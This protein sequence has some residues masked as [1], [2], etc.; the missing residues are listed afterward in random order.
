MELQLRRRTVL[1]AGALALG[2]PHAYSANA[3]IAVSTAIN[4]AGRLRALSQRSA[5]AYTQ[6]LLGILPE[7]AREIAQVAQ[8]LIGAHL[9]ELTHAK[10]PTEVARLLQRAVEM[11]GELRVLME[12][13]RT[14]EGALAV[15]R[16]ADLLLEAA[17][18]ATTAYE[19]LGKASSARLINVAARQRML[20]QRMTK[21]YFL[22]AAGYPAKTYR[23]PIDSDRA[24]F[25]QALALLNGSA[26]STP[27]IRNELGLAQTQWLFFEAALSKPGDPEALRNVATT[28]ERLLETMN[29]LTELYDGALKDLL[30]KA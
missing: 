15:S 25:T 4:R 11:A 27:S 3:Q 21:N 8:R 24:A 7:H 10:P 23:D 9:E 1:R 20:S 6:E 30:G 13:P 18:H 17:D 12:R 14:K 19:A 22:I 5:K 16:Q 26:L 29:N 28:S 2:M